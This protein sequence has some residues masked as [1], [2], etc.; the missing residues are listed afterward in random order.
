MNLKVFPVV[1]ACFGF[2][3]ISA[4]TPNRGTI[5]QASIGLL[6]R[7]SVRKEIKVS[8]EQDSMIQAEF[9]RLNDAAKAIFAKRPK[10]QAEATSSRDKLRSMQ[11]S[12]VTR[13]QARLTTPQAR[14]VREIALQQFGPFGM[15]SPEIQS[16][17]GLNAAQVNKIKAAQKWLQDQL[18]ALQK[19]RTDEVRKIPQPK[20]RQDQK[21]VEAYVKKVNDLMAKYGAGDRKTVASYKKQ[22]EA[23]VLAALTAAQRTKW[24]GMLGA[25]FKIS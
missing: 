5:T 25:P 19:K 14:R 13:I 3:V 2:V 9:K 22:A 12:L 15:L 16:E 4:Q 1:L 21:A 18:Q 23:K 6:E 8:K 17:M 11:M 7:A 24:S 20:D 10:D